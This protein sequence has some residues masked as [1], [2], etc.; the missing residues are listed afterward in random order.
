MQIPPPVRASVE[1]LLGERTGQPVHLTRMASVGGGC[2]SPAARVETD[3]GDVA[4]LKWYERNAPS[5]AVPSAASLFAAE[6]A[7][8]QALADTGAVRVPRVL[9]VSESHVF[10]WLLL[11]WL[12]P[13]RASPDTWRDLGHG[14]ARLHGTAAERYGWPTD[15]Y[16]ADLPQANGWLDVWSAFWRERRLRPQLRRAIDAGHLAAASERR[17]FERLL[18]RLG[19]LLAPAA[20]DGASLLHGD[21]WA[22]NVH[23]LADAAPAV[24]DPSSY[25]GHREV[26]LAMSELFGG[27]DEGFYRAYQDAWPLAP[28]YRTVR[29]PV[30]QL[31]YLLVHVNLFG[32]GYVQP[33]LRALAQTGV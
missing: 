5:Q 27:F 28:E 21:L 7:A 19:D 31:Y 20:S 2:V 22:G 6:A 15:N 29:R 1:A 33:T 26:D 23:I 10:S 12:E 9:A 11:E 3:A 24:I 30:Y 18:D 16:I 17:R 32:N 25:Y 13:G 14:L 4:F 8:L